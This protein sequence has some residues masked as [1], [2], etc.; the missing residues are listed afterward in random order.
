[1][2]Y[3]LV[4]GSC[5]GVVVSRSVLSVPEALLL[6]FDPQTYKPKTLK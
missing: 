4:S 5:Y 6:T 3:D 2:L 1:M